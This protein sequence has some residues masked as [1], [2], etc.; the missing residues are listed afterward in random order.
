MLIGYIGAVRALQIER[1]PRV[2]EDMEV[3]IEIVQAVLGMTL[4]D[5]TVLVDGERIASAELK[6]AIAEQNR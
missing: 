5:A 4:A 6:I 3:R 2:G 1:L